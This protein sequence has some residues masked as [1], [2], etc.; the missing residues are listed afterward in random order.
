MNLKRAEH[1]TDFDFIPPG[2]L[3]S[4]PEFPYHV[5]PGDWEENG[6]PYGAWYRCWKC[7]ELGRST[8]SYDCHA[9]KPGDELVCEECSQKEWKKV[10]DE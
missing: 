2:Q 8:L 7:K 9:A 5:A 10:N 6:V 1:L 4:S 3:G